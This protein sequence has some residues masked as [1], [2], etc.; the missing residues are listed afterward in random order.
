MK[1][2]N[3]FWTKKLKFQQGPKNEHFLK[4]L[5]H[6]FCPKIELSLIAFFRRNYARK[7]RFSLFQIKNNHF[8]TKKID[9]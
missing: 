9:V 4:R 6:G 5:A 1:E 2:N 3:Y 7:G 8:K